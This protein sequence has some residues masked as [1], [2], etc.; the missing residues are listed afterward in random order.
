MDQDLTG[1]WSSDV[2]RRPGS[3]SEEILV[4]KCDGSGFYEHQNPMTDYMIH[5]RWKPDAFGLHIRG[6]K[7]GEIGQDGRLTS[8]DSRLDIDCEFEL[9][10][11]IHSGEPVPI[12]RLLSPREPIISETFAL[13]DRDAAT[14]GEPDFSWLIEN[15][16][17]N[18]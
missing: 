4:F 6:F 9:T 8:R 10:Q 17:P 13:V 5:F 14:Y 2:L 3:Q 16:S 12:L 18:H 7:V 1:V 11:A 15:R